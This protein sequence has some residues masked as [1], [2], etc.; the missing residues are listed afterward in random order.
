MSPENPGIAFSFVLPWTRHEFFKRK[1]VR[2]GFWET[3]AVILSKL[4]VPRR[5]RGEV[6][7]SRSPE[8]L[9]L[10]F[11]L[12]PGPRY[13]EIAPL[14]K[15]SDPSADRHTAWENLSSTRARPARAAAMA[16]AIPPYFELR[17]VCRA[18]GFFLPRWREME[19]TRTS[20]VWAW[21][22]GRRRGPESENAAPRPDDAMSRRDGPGPTHGW[23]TWTCAWCDFQARLR[24]LPAP[25]RD[26]ADMYAGPRRVRYASAGM[27][28]SP[29]TRIS[30]PWGSVALPLLVVSDAPCRHS[31]YIPSSIYLFLSPFFPSSTFADAHHIAINT[32]TCAQTLCVVA[33]DTISDAVGVVIV[34]VFHSL[35]VPHSHSQRLCPFVVLIS[36]SSL[37][38]FLSYLC[39]GI[40]LARSRRVTAG[41]GTDALRGVG[42]F[43]TWAFEETRAAWGMLRVRVSAFRRTSAEAPLD[44]PFAQISVAFHDEL[45]RLE[46]HHHFAPSAACG[47]ADG[48]TV[49][50]VPEPL[51]CLPLLVLMPIPQEQPCGRWYTLMKRRLPRKQ[52]LPMLVLQ[53]EEARVLLL[54]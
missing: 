13:T 1:P 35:S 25:K 23:R 5:I 17:C 51:W 50:M 31:H 20:P 10:A 40:P 12:G 47:S 8:K 42:Q 30:G 44:P 28:V 33:N 34:A 11:S 46:R 22:G 41:T 6:F 4:K 21:A 32:I 9:G 37:V 53:A 18:E 14:F 39:P 48:D 36:V 52:R 27:C 2:C 3:T 29:P 38:V 54:G 19:G 43:A 26:D 49:G 16:H 24:A 15:S 7:Y 45:V